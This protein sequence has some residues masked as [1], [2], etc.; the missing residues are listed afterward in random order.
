MDFLHVSI[1]GG[2]ECWEPVNGS[3]LKVKRLHTRVQ[4]QNIIITT[5]IVNYI[6]RGGRRRGTV[7]KQIIFSSR[8]NLIINRNKMGWRKVTLLEFENNEVPLF[9]G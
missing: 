8:I 9:F 1:G 2:S 4:I 3:Q 5:I 7:L 6:V